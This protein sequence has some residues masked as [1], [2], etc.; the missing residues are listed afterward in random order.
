[1][2]IFTRARKAWAMVAVTVLTFLYTAFDE[3]M[4]SAEWVLVLSTGLGAFGTYVVDNLD[5]GIARYAKAIVA[6]LLPALGIAAVQITDGLTPQ[7]W[8]EALLAGAAGVGLVAGLRNPGYQFSH[9]DTVGAAARRTP[10]GP[11]PGDQY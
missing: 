8:I 4:T 10:S 1:M 3:G 7:E 5:V 9:K 2:S 6:F 11:Q